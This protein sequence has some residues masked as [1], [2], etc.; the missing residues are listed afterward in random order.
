MFTVIKV[1][2][3]RC[4]YAVTKL[5]NPILNSIMIFFTT[6]GDFGAVWLLLAAIFL[7]FKKLRK[8]GI[9]IFLGELLNIIVVTILK[10]TIQRPRPFLTLPNYHPLITPPTSFSFPSGHAS[11]AI[12]AALII[13][14]YLKKWAIPAF[15]LAF[16]IGFSRIYVGVHYPSDVIVGFLI[17]IICGYLV[18]LFYEHFLCKKYHRILK[19]LKIEY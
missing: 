6:I 15:T 18:M 1:L 19:K 17:G 4:M 13:A 9:L 2:D 8:V 16:I 14:Y 12:V 7:F 3:Y 11:S 10:D 5:H